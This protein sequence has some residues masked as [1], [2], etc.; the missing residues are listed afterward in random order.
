MDK[1]VEEFMK[2]VI[3]KNPGE[4]EFHQA[5]QEFVTTV[6]PYVKKN[7]RYQKA[8]ILERLVEPERVVMFRVSWE[9][10]NGE[11]HVN[12]GYRVQFNSAIGPYKGGLR[13]HPSVY[14]G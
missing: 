12:R 14:L 7:P 6:M 10:D 3:E 9:D 2:N 5:V 4:Q 8:K 13:F 11:I 1:D